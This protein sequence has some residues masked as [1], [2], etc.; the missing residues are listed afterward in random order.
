MIAFGTLAVILSSFSAGSVASPPFEPVYTRDVASTSYNPFKWIFPGGVPPSPGSRL[1][2][3]FVDNETAADRVVN[4]IN[5]T[6]HASDI[7][8]ACFWSGRTN[9]K[10]LTPQ[11]Q[12]NSTIS[13]QTVVVA[14]QGDP[15]NCNT[16]IDIVCKAGEKSASAKFT[17]DE[18]N[19]LSRALAKNVAGKAYALL[20]GDIRANSTWL[21]VEQPTLK[22]NTKVTSLE[23][24]EIG[25][26]GAP[27]KVAL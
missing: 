16:L 7:N 11:G 9:V 2:Q 8:P 14:F 10:F 23:I 3:P 26:D 17:N 25:S 20:G 4:Y 13:A 15:R 5:N 21:T 27:A 1:I 12:V 18:W 22:N 19:D 6:V 24:W